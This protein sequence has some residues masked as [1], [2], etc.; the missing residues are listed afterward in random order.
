MSNPSP[1]S[2]RCVPAPFVEQASCNVLTL[3]KPDGSNGATVEVPGWPFMAVEQATTMHVCG[4]AKDG[5]P[6]MLRIANSEPLTQQEFEEGWR[7]TIAWDDLQ[8]LQ[9]NSQLV[10][11]FQVALNNSGCDCPLLFPPISLKVRVPFEDL[12]TFSEAEEAPWNGWKKGP[13]A[14]DPRDLVVGKDGD[15]YVLYNRTY[16]DASAGIILAK[17][18][19]NLEAGTRYEFGLQVRRTN[20]SSSVPSLSLAA[21]AQNVTEAKDFPATTWESLEGTFTA[22]SSQCTLAIISHTASGGGNDYAISRIW[23]KSV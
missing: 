14:V 3:N 1:I 11:I 20:T 9:H 10:F 19:A 8:D 4:Q 21:G 17:N 16:T 7:R 2:L 5:S 13:A 6:I 15:I 22:D 23:V 18:F 12:T